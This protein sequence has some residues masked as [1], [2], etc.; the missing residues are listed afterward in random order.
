TSPGASVA[1]RKTVRAFSCAAARSQLHRT[2]GAGVLSGKVDRFGGVT[3]NLADLGLPADISESSFSR[4]LQ[5]LCT[6]VW[7][8]EEDARL[9][10]FCTN[11]LL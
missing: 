3:V 9:H 10:P 5:G 6:T 8:K 7:N 11:N 1:V 2:E 4:L